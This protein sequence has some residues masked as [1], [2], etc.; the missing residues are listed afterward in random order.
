LGL[1]EDDDGFE[2]SFAAEE[3]EMNMELFGMKGAL[4]GLDD[5]EGPEP[6]DKEVEDLEVMMQKM[7]AI[8]EMGEGMEEA[9]RKR[10][11]A[12]AVNDLLKDL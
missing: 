2:G 10:F 3:A 4:A 7:V 1:G 9:E 12:K 8:K 5:D 11:A 6:G